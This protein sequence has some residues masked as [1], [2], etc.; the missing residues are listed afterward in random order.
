MMDS[1]TAAANESFSEHLARKREAAR[2]NQQKLRKKKADEETPEMKRVA[3]AL[4]TAKRQ[5]QRAR[6]ARQ[7]DQARETAAKASKLTEALIEEI[8]ARS[9][10]TCLLCHEADEVSTATHRCPT[11]CLVDKRVRASFCEKCWIGCRG[12][13][14]WC[15]SVWSQYDADD[16]AE[17]ILIGT[18][19]RPDS[20]RLRPRD[21]AT[22]DALA[23]M[24]IFD[25][26]LP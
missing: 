9:F 2:L 3:I 4:R 14:P 6:K 22:P 23:N 18:I 16:H 17:Q 12:R 25:Y 24:S 10:G 26:G 13:C 15:Y 19:A 8:D 20:R 7:S 1:L 21:A 11:R 5:A